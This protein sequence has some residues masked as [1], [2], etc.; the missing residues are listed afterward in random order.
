MP[1]CSKRD[2]PAPARL[3][4]Q[5][6]QGLTP[7]GRV[8]SLEEQI[9]H[10]VALLRQ[11]FVGAGR[12]PLVILGH[13]IGG[14]REAGCGCN[15][16]WRLMWPAGRSKPHSP[17][18]CLTKPAPHRQALSCPSTP[19]TASR[20]TTWAAATPRHMHWTVWRRGSGRGALMMRHQLAMVATCRR[21][22]WLSC[23]GRED[24]RGSRTSSRGGHYH[25]AEKS[26]SEAR[27]RSETSGRPPT[28]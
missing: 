13:S 11:H 22:W 9:Q 12:P 8:F 14:W 15:E 27:A 3:C 18:F 17:S 6:G 4:L 16:H 2:S 19:S 7:P 5:D 26:R 24:S 20:R 21:S 1:S 10:K 25:T 23:S 28:L